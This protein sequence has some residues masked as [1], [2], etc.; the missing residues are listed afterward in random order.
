MKW[1]AG[2]AAICAMTSHPARGAWIEIEAACKS[3]FCVGSHP[4]RGAWIEMLR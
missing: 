1:V 4:A 2:R 3:V